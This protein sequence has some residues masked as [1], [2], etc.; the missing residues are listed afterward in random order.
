MNGIPRRIRDRHWDS[1]LV[2]HDRS[3]RIADQEIEKS[4]WIRTGAAQ[5]RHFCRLVHVVIGGPVRQEFDLIA[6]LVLKA[7]EGGLS[8]SMWDRPKGRVDRLQQLEDRRHAVADFAADS[9]ILRDVRVAR[10]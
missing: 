9:E 6:I 8:G 2:Q 10:P 7:R 1:A 5:R 4:K 3:D